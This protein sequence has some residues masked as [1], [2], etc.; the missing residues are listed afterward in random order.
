MYMN[1]APHLLSE[2]RPDFERVLDQALHDEDT[3]QALARAAAQIN[4]EQLRTLALNATAA[5]N[6]CAAAEYAELLTVRGRVR[7]AATTPRGSDHP[8]Q[9]H[10]AGEEGLDDAGGPPGE[11]D[12]RTTGAGLTAVVAVLAP[13][14]AGAAAAIFLCV[15][16]VL[17]L[18]SPDPAVAAPMRAAGWVFAVVAGAGFVFGMGGLLLTALRNTG[19]DQDQL[20]VENSPEVAEA[21]ERWH[22]ALLER[23]IRPYLQ[24]A[25]AASENGELT[26]HEPPAA[27]RRTPP[28]GYSPPGFSSPNPEDP[29]APRHGPE[30]SRPDFTSPDFSSP[31]FDT[32]SS[33]HPGADRA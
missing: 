8:Y 26:I 13:I 4:P 10:P 19:A 30:F 15:G 2:D 3:R 28:L 1:S 9:Q 6:A 7:E 16:Y 21:R 11:A 24:G 20:R 25:L 12:A 32:G 18:M 27:E 14:L 31:D 23:G 29:E 17:E 5:I 22:H 33:D